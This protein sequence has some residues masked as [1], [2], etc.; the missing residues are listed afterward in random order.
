MAHLSEKLAEMHRRLAENTQEEQALVR[1]LNAAL[2]HVDEKLLSEIRHVTAQ[3]EARRAVIMNELQLLATR[4][5]AFPVTAAEPMA[6]IE[7]DTHAA[8]AA[9]NGH[10]HRNG[11][12]THAPGNWRIAA[13]N[14]QD[15]LDFF[16]D[17]QPSSH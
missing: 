6:A 9:A 8:R 1:A 10:A 15:D 2:N 7:D 12:A 3:H 11:A 17:P 16:T 5:C 4:L 14:I 13:Q